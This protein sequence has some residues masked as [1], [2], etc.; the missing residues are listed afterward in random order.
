MLP[1]VVL[2]SQ[3]LAPASSPAFVGLTLSG[4]TQGSVLFGGAGGALSQD[5][6]AFNWNDS[7]KLLTVNANAVALP[8]PPVG[9]V[10]QVG[11]ADAAIT[12]I[13]LDSFA[14]SSQFVG[15]RAQGTAAL[16]TA[17]QL[18]N[19]LV[20]LA[21]LGYG[22]TGYSTA[23]GSI[24][25]VAAENWTDTAH[26][27]NIVF[28]TAAIGAAA[29]TERARLT[30]AG[31]SILNQNSL[32]NLVVGSTAGTARSYNSITDAL[33]SEWAYGAADWGVTA[34]VATY[35]TDKN[36]TGLTRNLQFVVGGANKLDYGITNSGLWSASTA[37]AI[38]QGTS[39]YSL[40]V[41]NTAGGG[42][43]VL[44][45][46]SG[47]TGSGS[48]VINAINGSSVTVFQVTADGGF[49][50]SSAT[51]HSTNVSLTNGAAA[52]AGTL[53]NAPIAGNPT[54][55]VPINDNGTTRYIP[56]W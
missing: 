5:N 45:L 55:W 16:P 14:V 50:F 40:S 42:S 25:L 31:L 27:T 39:G 38:S 29:N 41:I 32:A 24:S 2:P 17:I 19:I 12:R 51:L 6:A 22:A 18:N 7:G 34:N 15:R 52:A 33:N 28:N 23:G 21:G 36:G 43:N 56:A 46:V 10:L 1:A 53:L 49:S 3:G 4:L 20:S 48:K 47:G 9:T 13:V 26:G 44:S 8:A 30:S 11:A 54:K 35:G 37:L